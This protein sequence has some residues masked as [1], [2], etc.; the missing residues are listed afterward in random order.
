M[1]A[2]LLPFLSLLGLFTTH[3]SA[4][5]LT[6]KLVPNEKEC[7]YTHIEKPGVKIAFYFAVQTGG[8]FDINY[9]VYGPA[10]EPGKERVVLEGE[11]ERQGDFVF[12]AN[13]AGEYRFCF[14]N[15][16]STVSDKL[17]DFEIAVRPQS[18]PPTNTL[19][20]DMIGYTAQVEN[21]ARSSLPQKAGATP[22]QLSGVEETILKLS[23]QVSTLVRQQKYFR[24]RENR[25]FSTVRS[26]EGR[27]FRFS[28]LE[29]GLM[30]AMA[31]LQVFIVKMFFTGGRKGYV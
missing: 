5:A 3:A 27:I 30:V 13:E 23:G 28:L 8:S 29:S 17:V 24:T 20:T 14:D 25:N 31:A 16:M 26:T 4:T 6:Y 2:L 22:E 12:T 7:F 11:K 9:A 15:N 10:K 18:R 1:L 19:P 21:E